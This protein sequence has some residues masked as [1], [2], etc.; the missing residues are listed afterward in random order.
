MPFR[1]VPNEVF[2]KRNT[3]QLSTNLRC[4]ASFDQTLMVAPA[5]K[6]ELRTY[7]PGSGEDA[8]LTTFILEFQ[9]LRLVEKMGQK[10]GVLD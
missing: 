7:S 5:A 3:G 6:A 2:G 10:D 9:S 8:G 1:R 4:H